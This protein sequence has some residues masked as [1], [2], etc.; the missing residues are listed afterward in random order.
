M[1][2]AIAWFLVDPEVTL[3]PLEKTIPISSDN[4]IP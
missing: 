1:V 3:E 4:I 2:G